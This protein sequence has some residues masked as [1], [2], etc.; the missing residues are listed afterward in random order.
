MKVRLRFRLTSADQRVFDTTFINT[1]FTRLPLDYACSFDHFD[2]DGLSFRE[3]MC[4]FDSVSESAAD[5]AEKIFTSD[6][7][8]FKG[9]KVFAELIT[10]GETF[11]H[12]RAR[13]PDGSVQNI[14]ARILP[15][16]GVT[17]RL[18]DMGHF[19][20]DTAYIRMDVG[21]PEDACYKV[22]FGHNSTIPVSLSSNIGYVWSEYGGKKVTI[23]GPFFCHRNR[24]C[25]SRAIIGNM[26]FDGVECSFMT[27]E[28]IVTG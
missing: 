22:T 8:D 15:R 19:T 13:W 25:V 23:A 2:A 18:L 26:R 17:G 21:G 24:Y 10:E 12:Y 20:T 28:N 4:D 6:T 5:D 16:E 11:G 9:R 1:V 7:F 3:W 14:A 27:W